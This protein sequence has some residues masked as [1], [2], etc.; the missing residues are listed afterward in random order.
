MDFRDFPQWLLLHVFLILLCGLY[1]LSG[2]TSR[3]SG[4]DCSNGSKI[5]QASRQQ[6]CRDAYQIAALYDQYNRD[7]TRFGCKTSY[8]LVKRLFQHGISL[9]ISCR[10]HISRNVTSQHWHWSLSVKYHEEYVWINHLNSLRTDFVT[11]TR[12]NTTQQH[13]IFI[14]HKGYC[15]D[16]CI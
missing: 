9:K 16:W 1:S 5:G 8:R 6:R 10:T 2:R 13:F 7:F 12:Q 15:G 4:L 11:T 14:F 3:N